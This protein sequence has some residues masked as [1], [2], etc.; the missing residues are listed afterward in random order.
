MK[1]KYN[2]MGSADRIKSEERRKQRKKYNAKWMQR[3]RTRQNASKK[4]ILQPKNWL[5]SSSDEEVSRPYKIIF[6]I[7][8]I[9]TV[10]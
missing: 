4:N 2:T 5:S 7:N 10:L 6:H 3:N 8:V 1:R 9:S